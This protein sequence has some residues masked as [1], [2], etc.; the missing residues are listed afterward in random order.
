MNLRSQS[1]GEE[2]ANSITHGLA[3][4]ASLAALPVLVFTAGGHDGWRLVGAT[5]FGVTLVL[6]YLTST[7]YHALPASRAKHVFRVFDHCAIYVL[8]AGT[9]TPFTLGALRGPWGWALLAAVWALALLGITAKCAVGLRYPR[10]STV[11]Y[12][13]MGWLALVA[14]RPLMTHVSP[15]GLAWLFAGGVCYTGGVAFYETDGRV[16]YGHT[17]WH[18]FVMAGSAC[19]FCAVLWHAGRAGMSGGV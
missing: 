8:I 14:L 16:R 7:L 2:I 12:L 9:Y 17:V 11:L 18:G 5:V 15:P 6:L 19:H 1:L 4:L 13:A 3:L 10:L